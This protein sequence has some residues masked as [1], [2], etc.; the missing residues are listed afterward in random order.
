[1]RLLP[2]DALAPA[3]NHFIDSGELNRWVDRQRQ[4]SGA[5][6]TRKLERQPSTG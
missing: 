6:T 4:A 5:T 2:R 3:I 1:M